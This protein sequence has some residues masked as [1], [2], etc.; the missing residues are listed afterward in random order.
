MAEE[1]LIDFGFSAVTAD[2]YEKD[3]TDGENTG[4][5]GSASP[6]ALASMDAKIEQIMSHLASAIFVL[7]KLKDLKIN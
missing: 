3:Q 7:H 2:E 5:G 6:D 4:G 1:E